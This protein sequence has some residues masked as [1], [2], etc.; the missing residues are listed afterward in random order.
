MKKL[1][2]MASIFCAIFLPLQAMEQ[3]KVLPIMP[4]DPWGIIYSFSHGGNFSE[5]LKNLRTLRLVCTAWNKRCHQ[6]SV[7]KTF[8]GNL[9][10]GTA[11]PE[12]TDV[13]KEFLASTLSND[14]TNPNAYKELLDLRV[15]VKNGIFGLTKWIAKGLHETCASGELGTTHCLLSLGADKDARDILHDYT[16]LH[17]AAREGRMDVVRLLLEKGANKDARGEYGYTPLHWAVEEKHVNVVRLLLEYKVDRQRQA[18]TV[19]TGMTAAEIAQ[20]K[21]AETKDEKYKKILELLQ[22]DSHRNRTCIIC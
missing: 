20:A 2:S 14:N 5:A 12:Q 21:F 3:N 22:E 13:F 17:W 7:L 18:R 15:Y 8:F 11:L 9:N 19:H 6:K 10:I 4:A 1:V 16:P